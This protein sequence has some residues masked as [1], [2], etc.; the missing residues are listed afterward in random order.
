[1]ATKR[2]TPSIQNRNCKYAIEDLIAKPCRA[3]VRGLSMT[4]KDCRSAPPKLVAHLSK[5][6]IAKARSCGID[7]SGLDGARHRGLGDLPPRA[8][9][10]KRTCIRWGITNGVRRC[11][12]WSKGW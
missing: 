1:M 3:F 2:Q 8:T 12:G 10:A 7:T 6:A 11:R 4:Y 5:K 9:R